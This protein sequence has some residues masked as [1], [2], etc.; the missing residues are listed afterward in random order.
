METRPP[1][2]VKLGSF[3]FDVE[4]IIDDNLNGLFSCDLLLGE[5]LNNNEYCTYDQLSYIIEEYLYNN[6][7][8]KTGS[9]YTYV[10]VSED[11]SMVFFTIELNYSK[12][13]ILPVFI[14][15]IYGEVKASFSIP[16]TV[17]YNISVNI[18]LDS[19]I[20]NND[21]V[22]KGSAIGI[23]QLSI[24]IKPFGEECFNTAAVFYNN[25]LY[26]LAITE[27]VIYVDLNWYLCDNNGN[28]LGDDKL[29]YEQLTEGCFKWVY[30]TESSLT[31]SAESYMPEIENEKRLLVYLTSN[32]LIN[33]QEQFIYI[34][35]YEDS[36]TFSIRDF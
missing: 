25:E 35:D 11:E 29:T 32:D 8:D 24:N 5:Y 16:C 1:A 21:S 22:L 18:E 2:K 9:L 4:N 31:F 30:C 34:Y 33:P 26:E 36:Y 14:Y 12:N 23:E 6:I 28:S 7:E 27:N 17:E 10:N 3:C 19:D 15:T 20:I 13:L